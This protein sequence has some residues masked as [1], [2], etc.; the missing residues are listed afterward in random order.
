MKKFSPPE[1]KVVLFLFPVPCSLLSSQTV[2]VT[3]QDIKNVLDEV[4]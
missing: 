2:E 3:D 4:T 1:M